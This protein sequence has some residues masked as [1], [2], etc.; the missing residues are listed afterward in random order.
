[1]R[2]GQPLSVVLSVVVLGL[3][4]TL[5]GCAEQT[6]SHSTVASHVQ[7]AGLMGT[8]W[9]LT[10]VSGPTGTFVVS[11]GFGAG[12]AVTREYL[13]SGR[14]GCAAFTARGHPATGGIT[15]SDVIETANGGLSD[16]GVLDASRA[17]FSQV[18]TPHLTRVA[19]ENGT[20]R[21]RTPTYTLTFEAVGSRP[22]S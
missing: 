19:V 21:L 10:R 2:V 7:R 9:T 14:D 13:L 1:M 3:S 8:R 5:T 17:A 6:T 15:V 22:A 16:H 11:P 18:L 20:L 12:L 4:V